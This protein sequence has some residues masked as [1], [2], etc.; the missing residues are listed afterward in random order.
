MCVVVQD[1][2]HVKC[3]SFHPSG[4]FLVVGTNHPVIRL[5][6]FN[7]GQCYVCNVP[8]H[9]HTAA[10]TSIKYVTSTTFIN[11]SIFY[12]TFQ[13]INNFK[14]FYIFYTFNFCAIPIRVHFSYNKCNGFS[15]VKPFYSKRGF[16]SL[17]F[18]LVKAFS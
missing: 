8:S 3:M 18:A 16:N 15:G 1:V 9:Q 13:K 4:D 14:Y 7:T 6:D 5:Y 11:S 10:I 17:N 12:R 2:E